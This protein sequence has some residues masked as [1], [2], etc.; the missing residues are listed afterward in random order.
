LSERK[1]DIH[2]FSFSDESETDIGIWRIGVELVQKWRFLVYGLI[3]YG[4]NDI[5]F[6]DSR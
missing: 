6:G 1:R 2:R 3:I 5:S 4:R